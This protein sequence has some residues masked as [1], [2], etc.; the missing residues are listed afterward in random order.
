MQVAAEGFGRA[1]GR[2]GSRLGFG[3]F[4]CNT[5]ASPVRMCIDLKQADFAV[6]FVISNVS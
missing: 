1:A 2:T 6:I 3:P 5:P 4:I